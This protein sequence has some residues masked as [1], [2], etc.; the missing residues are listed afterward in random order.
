MYIDKNFF[1]GWLGVFPHF[2]D[3]RHRFIFEHKNN[4]EPNMVRK[5]AG[6]EMIA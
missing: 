3:G 4:M 6:R 2:H 5:D 1:C